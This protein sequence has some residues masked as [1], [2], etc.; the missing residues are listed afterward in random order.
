MT[1]NNEIFEF[2][3]VSKRI[4]Q[5]LTRV[6]TSILGVKISRIDPMLF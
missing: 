2:C 6:L 5:G 4:K 1:L 3:V